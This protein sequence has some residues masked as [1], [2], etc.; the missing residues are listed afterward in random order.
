MEVLTYLIFSQSPVAAGADE[1][2]MFAFQHTERDIA[3]NLAAAK[4]VGQMFNV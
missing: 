3:E 2:D 1:T 4:V